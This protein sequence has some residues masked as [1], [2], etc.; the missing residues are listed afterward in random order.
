MYSYHSSI[1]WN[2]KS[3]Q[4]GNSHVFHFTLLLSITFDS[5]KELYLLEKA[6]SIEERVIYRKGAIEP[7]TQNC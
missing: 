2:S 3:C 4:R 1:F 7:I 5:E 6:T